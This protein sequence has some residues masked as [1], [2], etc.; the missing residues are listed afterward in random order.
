M[1]LLVRPSLAQDEQQRVSLSLQAPPAC[2]T[3]AEFELRLNQLTKRISVTPTPDGE[4]AIVQ[5]SKRGDLYTGRV[6]VPSRDLDR[7]VTSE[8]C[9]D[10]V[11][12]LALILALSFDPNA[13]VAE[14]ETQ[15]PTVEPTVSSKAETSAAPAPVTEPAAQPVSTEPPK[16]KAAPVAP[17]APAT[18]SNDAETRTRYWLTASPQIRIGGPPGTGYGAVV[19]LRRV[20]ASDLDQFVFAVGAMTSA[21]KFELGTASFRQA[22]ATLDWCPRLIDGGVAAIHLCVGIQVGASRSDTS[23]NLDFDAE[24]ARTRPYLAPTAGT[25]WAVPLAASWSLVF[26]TRVTSPLM[27]DRF[28][29]ERSDGRVEQVLVTRRFAWESSFGVGYAL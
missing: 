26:F 15:Q 24:S 16:P 12:A 27:S 10:S 22:L 11:D 19:G 5:V 3:Q 9:S 2:P 17:N 4:R 29:V 23:S 13:S 6:V 21:Q 25:M 14:P 18:T 1:L 20:A 7:T 28:V 8:V